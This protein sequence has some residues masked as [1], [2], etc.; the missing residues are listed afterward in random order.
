MKTAYSEIN[1]LLYKSHLPNIIN[2]AIEV[3]LFEAL[4]GKSLSCVQLSLQIACDERICESLLE[5]LSAINYLEKKKGLYKLTA[6]SNDYL[7]KSSEVN[8]LSA[9]KSFMITSGPFAGLTDALKGNIT[10]YDQNMWSNEEAIKDIE[11]GSKSGAIQNVVAFAKEIPEFKKARKMCDFAGNS[12]YYSYA[13]LKGNKNLEAHVYDLDEVCKIA[14]RIKKDEEDFNRVF[15]HS[16][17][18]MD[19]D[20]FGDE[21]DLFFSSH[22]LYKY[23]TKDLLINLLKKVNKSMK[24]GALF[25]SNH[26]GGQVHGDHDLTLCI[27]ELMTRSMNFP[28]HTLAENTLKAALRVAGFGKFRVKAPDEKSAYPTVLLSAVKVKEIL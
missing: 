16:F 10:A 17:D 11:Q 8:Q 2:S 20:D 3:G 21:Y 9:I 5:I 22:F 6:L 18:L 12:G 13:L 19:D 23:N 27:I 14:A 15:Y 4:Q 7:L 24:M 26:I 25:I 1:N 28:T